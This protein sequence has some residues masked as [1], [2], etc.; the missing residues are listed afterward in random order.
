MRRVPRPVLPQQVSSYLKSKRGVVAQRWQAQTLD[1][2]ALWKQSR[3][4]QK[5]RQALKLLQQAMGPRE[6]CMYCLDS[7]GTDIEHFWPKTPYPRLAFYW[8]NWLL[9]CTE[10]GRIKGN[11]FPLENSKPLLVNPMRE[12]P[13][14][15]IDFDPET[16]NLM[17]RYDAQ[18][19]DWNR[20]GLKT[21]ETLHLDAREAL[22]AGYR[23]TFKKLAGIVTEALDSL[24][25][26]AEELLDR[27]RDEDEHGLL[28][29]CFSASGSQAKP[30]SEL[31]QRAPELWD[32]CLR[33]V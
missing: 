1:I 22:A 32:S 13:W 7:H 28:A 8:N 33:H 25:L 23:R 11:Q 29:W 5:I 12:D 19:G 30:F 10:C 18:A 27:L 2:E 16:G 4:T 21:V 3:Q 17:A 6:R 26:T 14:H 9:C 20:K 24:P 31:K 15:F